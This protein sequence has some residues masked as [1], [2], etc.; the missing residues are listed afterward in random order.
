MATAITSLALGTSSKK[1]EVKAPLVRVRTVF[2]RGEAPE[3]LEVEANLDPLEILKAA[4]VGVLVGGVALAAGWLIWD[5]LAFPGP[6]GPVQIF[7][8]IKTVPWW[9]RQA[10]RAGL[11][12]ENR[13]AGIPNLEKAAQATDSGKIPCDA[14]RVFY[15]GLRDFERGFCRRNDLTREECLAAWQELKARCDL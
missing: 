3:I 13:Q 2:Q 14:A 4:G 11:R 6:T 5:G 12:L 7:N 9:Q 15:S 8:G 1:R 10:E